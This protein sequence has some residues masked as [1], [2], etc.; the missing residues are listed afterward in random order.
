MVINTFTNEW[1]TFQN[2]YCR[3]N[4]ALKSFMEKKTYKIVMKR[5]Q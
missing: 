2:N 3:I 1:K 5:Y 4:A